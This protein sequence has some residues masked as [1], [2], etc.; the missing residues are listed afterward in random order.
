V[1]LGLTALG[2][3][4]GFARAYLT[5]LLTSDGYLRLAAAA[6]TPG[7]EGSKSKPC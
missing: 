2:F 7:A 4:H 5:W 6:L 3:P 1:P